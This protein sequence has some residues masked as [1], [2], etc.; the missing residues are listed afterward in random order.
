MKK[1][2]YTLVR[3]LA[4]V[5]IVAITLTATTNRAMAGDGYWDLFSVNLISGNPYPYW[6]QVSG[7]AGSLSDPLVSPDPGGNP[8]IDT[9]SP[10]GGV[11]YGFGGSSWGNGSLESV[12]TVDNSIQLLGTS[13]YYLSITL[14][15]A[16]DPNSD[17]TFPSWGTFS[18]IAVEQ[19]DGTNWSAYTPN[20]TVSPYSPGG[21]TTYTSNSVTVGLGEIGI[22]EN[23]QQAPGIYGVG[24]FLPA[25]EGY[26]VS[27]DTDLH[28][29]DSYTAI[30]GPGGGQGTPGKPSNSIPSLT[31]VPGKEYSNMSDETSGG[32]LDAMQNIAL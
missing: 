23:G 3:V 16:S 30:G 21:G 26:R 1:D 25:A 5:T 27:F 19:Y 18:N 11:T 13:T 29:W 22:A 28:T 15:T 8:I 4:A 7:G 20:W 14:D 17:Y 32:G 24:G 6:N 10:L 12:V 2:T 9:A 31:A